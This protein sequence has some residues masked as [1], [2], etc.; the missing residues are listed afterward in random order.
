MDFKPVL[1]DRKRPDVAIAKINEILNKLLSENVEVN[2]SVERIII[3]AESLDENYTAFKSTVEA[4]ITAIA[5]AFDSDNFAQDYQSQ[6]DQLASS[7]GYIKESE[8]SD[9]LTEHGYVPSI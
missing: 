6:F 9:W 2:K 3:T 7:L 8:L 1:Y 4:D 5:G